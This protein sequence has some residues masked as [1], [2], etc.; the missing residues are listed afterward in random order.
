MPRLLTGLGL[1][2][3][4]EGVVGC[5]GNKEGEDGLVWFRWLFSK[6]LTFGI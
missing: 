6:P 5:Y 2:W 3:L 4:G 1:V